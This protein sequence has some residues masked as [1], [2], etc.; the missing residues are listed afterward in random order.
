[1]ADMAR[2]GRMVCVDTEKMLEE[3]SGPERFGPSQRKRRAQTKCNDRAICLAYDEVSIWTTA[4]GVG[5][6]RR[7]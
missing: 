4:F 6:L 1:M 3:G 5:M 2:E 7:S